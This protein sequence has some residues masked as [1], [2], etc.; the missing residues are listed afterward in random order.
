MILLFV[1][2]NCKQ[3]S[4]KEL[5]Y[6]P[7]PVKLYV[8]TNLAWDNIRRLEETLTGKSTSHQ[9][10]GVAVHANIYGPYLTATELPHIEKKISQY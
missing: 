5:H 4:T 2:R 7:A 10:N 8:F 9:V 1:S 3:V 6:I